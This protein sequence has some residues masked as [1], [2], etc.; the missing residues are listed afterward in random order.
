MTTSQ[1]K[2]AVED[3]NFHDAAGARCE[4]TPRDLGKAM[5]MRPRVLV[6]TDD[7]QIG[8]PLHR[9]LEAEYEVSWGSSLDDPFAGLLQDA[10][11]AVV[12]WSTL[13]RLVLETPWQDRRR[14][15]RADSAVGDDLKAVQHLGTILKSL[16]ASSRI[17][18]RRT[19]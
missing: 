3:A 13:D 2:H 16:S 8:H 12:D 1:D 19:N 10:E 18:R 4:R 5:P 9:A 14:D 15:T 7:Q 11:L 17:R 6:V